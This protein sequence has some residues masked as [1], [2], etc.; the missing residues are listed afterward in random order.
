MEY[1]ISDKDIVQEMQ[2]RFPREAEIA[3][4]TVV[5]RLQTQALRELRE[6]Q[7]ASVGQNKE[8]WDSETERPVPL[9]A[10]KETSK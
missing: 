6:A 10:E 7:E 2:R 1:L 4:L 8:F 3:T 9:R 5:N